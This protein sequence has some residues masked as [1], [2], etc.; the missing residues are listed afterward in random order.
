MHMDPIMPVLVGVIFGILLCGL[1]ITKLRQ[2]TAIGYL[3]AGIV[4]GPYGLNVIQDTLTVS[5]IGEFGVILLLFFVGMEISLPRLVANWKIPIIGTLF[6]IGLS[7][8]CVIAVGSWLDWPWARMIL[9]GFVISLSSTAVIIKVL[10]DWGELKTDVGQDVLGILL[11][12]DLAIIPMLIAIDLM[13]GRSLHGTELIL[14]IV[15]GILVVS[16]FVGLF[17]K[18]SFHL[19]FAK[20]LQQD[21]EMQVFAAMILCFG[22]SFLTGVFHLSTALGAFVAGI[23]IGAAKETEWVHHSLE[24]FRIVFL[25]IFFVAIGMLMDLKFIVRHLATIAILVAAV[26]LTNT[27]INAAILRF[28]KINWRRSLYASSLLAQ[29]GEFSF[30][31]V[32]VGMQVGI[33]SDFTYQMTLI[34]IST[35]L[36]L[37]PFWIQLMKLITRY[38]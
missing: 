36:L 20:V 28:L 12:Q 31:I 15:G 35:T 29:I 13:A 32:A 24:P 23:L 25:A 33:I 2:P 37:S 30:V 4:L 10:N 38:D 8:A 34:V 3:L 27:F 21:K 22:L 14:Q 7:L 17:I 18:K 19:P 11:V 5:R 9:L 26:F 16:L 1:I 6:Q